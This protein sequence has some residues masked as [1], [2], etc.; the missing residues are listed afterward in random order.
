M[1]EIMGKD[2]MGKGKRGD[3]CYVRRIVPLRYPKSH[4]SDPDSYWDRNPLP[5][6]GISSPLSGLLKIRNSKLH[7][8][9]LSD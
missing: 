3:Y 9:A 6:R 4:T 2:E 1:R 8:F 7:I 5:L